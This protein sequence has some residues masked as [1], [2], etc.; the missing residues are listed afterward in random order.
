MKQTYTSEWSYH[1]AVDDIGKAPVTYTITADA[2]ACAGLANRYDIPAVLSASA[3]LILTRENN[4]LVIRVD[5][6][7]QARVMYTCVV[8]LDPFE[9]VVTDTFES[10][11]AD[12]DQA[13]SFARARAD[14][15]AKGG[16]IEVEMMDERDAPEDIINGTIDVGEM[17][18]Q[19][20]SLAL[21]PYPRGP[22]AP[23]DTSVLDEEPD[24]DPESDTA[25]SN[26]FA[27]LKE[28]KDKLV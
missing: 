25:H 14:L 24:Q 22:H 28:W 2:D 7:V 13:I 21:D 20:L 5:G 18:A 27:A 3:T 16:D 6:T 26:P 19:Y 11:F 15:R 12:P 17:V 9:S 10:F 1:I 23:D 4:G 8:T